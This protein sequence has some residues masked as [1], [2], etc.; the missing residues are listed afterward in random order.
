M[1]TPKLMEFQRDNSACE[2]HYEEI[3]W[4]HINSVSFHNVH[5]VGFHAGAK[6]QHQRDLVLLKKLMEI[7]EMQQ[8]ILK[9]YSDKTTQYIVPNTMG[10]DHE[11]YYLAANPNYNDI[12][13]TL[14]QVDTMIEQLNKGES[15]EES[16]RHEQS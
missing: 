13:E 5:S 1:I 12:R 7:V 11:T 4:Q 2:K 14:A 10:T 16:N 6:H 3:P 9:K 15:G 8:T